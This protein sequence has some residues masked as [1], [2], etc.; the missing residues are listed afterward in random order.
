MRGKKEENTAHGFLKSFKHL[1]L[2]L[3]EQMVYRHDVVVLLM[4]SF[5]KHIN[6]QPKEKTL[7][8]EVLKIWN[9]DGDNGEI[10]MKTPI[11]W[12]RAIRIAEETLKENTGDC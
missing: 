10:Q 12:H 5:A 2:V 1:E 7:A 6:Q 8:E 9:E 3:E 4:S 11:A